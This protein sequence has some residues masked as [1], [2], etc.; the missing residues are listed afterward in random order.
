MSASHN[1]KHRPEVVV[2]TGASAGVGRAIVRE[3][4]RHGA[5]VG[6][7]ARGRD[8]LEGARREVEQ[9]GG[10][11]LVVPTDMADDGQVEQAADM[12]ERHLGPIDI[13]INN[14]MVSVLSPAKE[15]TAAEYRRVTEVTYLGYVHGTL[16]ALRRMLPRDRGVIVQ[17]GSAL[18]YRAIPLQSAYCAAKHAVQGFTESL[19][20]ELI[21]DH[22][23]VHLTIVQLPAVNTPQF[24]WIKTRMPRHPQPVPPIYQPEVIAR[25]VYW[26]AHHRRREFSVGYPTVQAIIGDKFI[27][28]L[29]D[30]YLARVG[31]ERQQTDEPVDP[32]RPNNLYDPLPG[33]HG[34]HG[35]FDQDAITFSPQSWLNRYRGWLGAAG[36]LAGLWAVRRYDLVK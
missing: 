27:P 34:A 30:R 26:A 8:G 17:I 31:Y 16:A 28:G 11:A 3:F 9:A 4:A 23:R 12:V 14:A 13:W 20:S 7:L 32:D 10:K 19:R 22:S 25:S 33:D 2:V 21:H 18:A 1:G 36:L 29:L 24:S 5:A 15:M 6:L 35:R